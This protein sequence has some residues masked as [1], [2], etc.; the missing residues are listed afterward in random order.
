MKLCHPTPLTDFSY[1]NCRLSGQDVCIDCEALTTRK[2]CAWPEQKQQAL[3]RELNR[4]FPAIFKKRKD[5]EYMV[6]HFF[7]LPCGNTIRQ[8]IFAR[9]K[10]GR[11]V[12]LCAF[13]NGVFHVGSQKTHLIY[14]HIRAVLPAFQK[15]GMGRMFSEKILST[16]QPDMLMTTCVQNTSYFSWLKIQDPDI[17]KKYSFFPWSDP[18][19]HGK[20]NIRLP[21]EDLGF[22]LDCFRAIYKSHVKESQTRLDEVINNIT[23]HLIRKGVNTFFDHPK[24]D[25]NQKK[26]SIARYLG[27]TEK[28]AILLVIKKRKD[29][30]RELYPAHV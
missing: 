24:W 23:V 18:H 15:L 12:A 14:V 28:D 3:A 6:K 29:G 25:E 17:R 13:D 16:L 11:L 30:D 5:W 2:I 19:G 21:Y 20:K 4:F 22:T 8:I 7:Y 1:N 9:D 10:D 26:L 27:V